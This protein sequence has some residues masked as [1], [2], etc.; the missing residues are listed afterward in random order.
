MKQHHPTQPTCP[1]CGY[2]LSGLVEPHSSYT[3]PECSTETSY[4]KA[5]T[6]KP[7]TQTIKLALIFVLA[8]PS[9]WG[10]FSWAL[11]YLGAMLDG[12]ELILILS[13]LCITSIPI[14][15]IVLL[16]LDWKSRKR[17]GNHLFRIEFSAVAFVIICSAAI[18]EMILLFSLADWAEAIASV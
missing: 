6:R 11:L 5:T 15:S 18:S 12:A 8:I 13:P 10:I 17:C 4:E 14:L 3:C 1:S 9:A 16:I 7:P 2:D